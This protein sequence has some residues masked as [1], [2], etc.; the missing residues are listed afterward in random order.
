MIADAAERFAAKSGYQLAGVFAFGDSA[1]LAD[2]LLDFVRRG[3]KRATAGAVAELEADDDPVP[4][5]GLFWGLLDG[6][7]SPQFVIETVEVR[8]GRL[9]SVDPAF[10]WD[11]GEGDR[12]FES[13]LDNHRR[14]FQRQGVAA[15]HDLEV[16]FE[17]FRVVWP[18]PDEPGQLAEGVRELR[19]DERPWAIE[20]LV[21]RWGTTTVVSRGLVQDTAGLPALVAERD[22]QRVGLLTFRPRPGGQT[23]IVTVDAF[24]LGRGIGGALLAGATALGRRNG[25]RRLWLITTNDNTRA[26]RS[27]QRHGFDL[28][29]LHRG[30]IDRFRQ[31]KPGIPLSDFDGIPISHELELELRLDHR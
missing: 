6:R 18:Q 27:Y 7:G 14:Y 5:P 19:F 8:R 17:R 2:E 22:G 16:L 23:E 15:P 26:L 4:V 11:E 29:E 13:W 24:E 21:Q 1:Q 20:A 9:D 25:W 12:T 31:L 30:A 10:A 3:T 28:A